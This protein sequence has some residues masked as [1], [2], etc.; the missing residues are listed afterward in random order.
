M[1]INLRRYSKDLPIKRLMERLFDAD[2]LKDIIKFG[3]HKDVGAGDELYLDDRKNHPGGAEG[4]TCKPS[5]YNSYGVHYSDGSKY[6][7]FDKLM[8]SDEQASKQ[9][10]SDALEKGAIRLQIK[11]LPDGSTFRSIAS[12]RSPIS[13]QSVLPDV[14]AGQRN[15]K[16]APAL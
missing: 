6:I 13:S 3:H 14:P 7:D 15:T 1:K 8:A 2:F 10:W 9:F 12:P 16:S 11:Y 4:L 5:P